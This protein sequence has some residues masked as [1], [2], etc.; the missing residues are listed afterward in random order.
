MDNSPQPQIVYTFP[1]KYGYFL[2]LEVSKN[3]ENKELIAQ[4]FADFSAICRTV[5]S[6]DRDQNFIAIMG[7]GSEMWD[8]IVGNPKPP[9]LHEF[10][11]LDGAKHAP[12]TV[13]DLFFH[14][15]CDSID[16]C[17]E[18]S[19]D[20]MKRLSTVTKIVDETHGFKYFNDLSM[21]GFVDGVE[22]PEYKKAMEATLIPSGSWANGSYLITQ[23]YLHNMDAWNKLTVEKQNQIIGRHKDTNIEI[24]DD[25]KQP[26]AHN[27]LTTITKNGVQIDIFRDNMPFGSPGNA[28]YGTF[29]VGYCNKASITEEMLRNMFIGSPKGTYD[30]ILDFSTAVSGNLW[31]IPTI[32]WLDEFSL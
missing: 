31:F 24:P 6:R 7:I 3:Q 23:K 2:T 18:M 4:F 10:I 11:E 21:L 20:I 17:F 13:G 28:E 5:R 19:Q 26:Y 16:M 12:S 29:F 9:E 22:N 32:D 1:R 14:I 15:R 30:K 8:W 27:K 25:E